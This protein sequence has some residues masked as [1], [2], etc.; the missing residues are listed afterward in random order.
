MTNRYILTKRITASKIVIFEVFPSLKILTF[1]RVRNFV[2]R[3]TE[4]VLRY[5]LDLTELLKFNAACI[6]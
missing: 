3:Q 2:H 6:S 5:F 1:G 4:I